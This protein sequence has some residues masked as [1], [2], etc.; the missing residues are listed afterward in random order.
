MTFLEDAVDELLRLTWLYRELLHA[1]EPIPVQERRRI[2]REAEERAG[3]DELCERIPVA[4]VCLAAL[5]Q[6]G[7]A[8]STST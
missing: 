6:R 4:F 3:F 1:E 2:M 8:Q 7:C 5:H